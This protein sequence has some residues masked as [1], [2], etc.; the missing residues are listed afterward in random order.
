MLDDQAMPEKWMIRVEGRE[1]GPADLEMLL[2]WKREGRVLPTN[3]VRREDAD[4][5]TTAASIPD[6]FEATG[7]TSKTPPPVQL[8]DQRLEVEGPTVRRNFGRILAQTARIYGSNFR[9]FFCLSLLIILP[10]ACGQLATG[11]IGGTPNVNVDLR[12]MVAAAFSFC[13]LVLTMVLWPIY[14]AAVQ[15][16]SAEALGGRRIGFLAAI[17]EAVKYWPRVAVL[18]LF[19]YVVFFLLISFGFAIAVMLWAGA[20]SF[21]VILFALGLLLVQVWLFGRFFIN[22]LFWQQFAVLENTGVVESL[23]ESRILARSGANLPWFKRPLWRGAFLVSIWTA[24]VLAIALSS[25]WPMLQEYFNLIKTTTDPQILVQKLSESSQAHTF[26][27]S[28]FGLSILQKILQPL[29]GIAFVV[30]FFDSKG[31]DQQ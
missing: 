2:E 22:V 27:L 1:Y 29:L 5:W 23:R 13:M 3:D 14:I 8:R 12:A 15:V 20:T 9:Q 18:C 19:V 11:L 26:P 16:L 17:N 7:A 31:E 21:L 24:V 28:A 25:Q 30:L 4:T 6:L 10:S